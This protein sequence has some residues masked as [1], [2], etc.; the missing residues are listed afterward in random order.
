M[1][2]SDIPSHWCMQ[3][4]LNLGQHLSIIVSML[5]LSSEQFVKT[6]RSRRG[7]H[8]SSSDTS[9]EVLITSNLR[10]SGRLPS[11]LIFAEIVTFLIWRSVIKGNPVSTISRGNHTAFNHRFS[12]HMCKLVRE[13]PCRDRNAF[14]E[15]WKG[16]QALN[17]SLEQVNGCIDQEFRGCGHRDI[18]SNAAATL[19]GSKAN[20]RRQINPLTFLSA[21]LYCPPLRW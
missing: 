7:Q 5:S 12:S 18:I 14:M 4:C 8:C 6:I 1:L 10:N 15:R 11:K 9:Q 20:S 17:S 13:D 3:I 2:S 21:L 19:L 16:S